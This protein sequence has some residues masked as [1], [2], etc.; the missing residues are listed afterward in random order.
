MPDQE[1]QLDLTKIAFPT[2]RL[3]IKDLRK[4][5]PAE[6]DG[7]D[8]R[9]QFSGTKL[10]DELEAT[11]QLERDIARWTFEVALGKA[12]SDWVKKYEIDPREDVAKALIDYG[13]ASGPH[14]AA[15]QIR[16]IES[17]AISQAKAFGPPS[18]T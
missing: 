3:S 18:R 14:H 11:L 5:F 2:D 12:S 13:L 10:G 8:E 1:L 16:D 15:Q 7:A 9:V 17:Q 4:R 6:F